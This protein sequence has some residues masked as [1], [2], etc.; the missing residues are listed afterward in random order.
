E[1][2]SQLPDKIETNFF[3]EMTEDQKKVYKTYVDDIKEKMKDADFNK[4]KITILSY[5]T[6]LRQLCL[7]P[8]IKIDNYNGESGKINVLNEIVSEN[9]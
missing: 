9:I 5:L 1:V 3:V 7:D 8:S 4:D 2:L 6:T